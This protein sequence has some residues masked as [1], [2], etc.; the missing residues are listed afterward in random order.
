[1]SEWENVQ[2]V[3]L[4]I[5]LD[6]L[7]M[8]LADHGDASD[9]FLDLK[10]GEMVVLPRSVTAAAEEVLPE[11]LEQWELGLLDRARQV[12]LEGTRYIPIEPL[13][14]QQFKQVMEDFI[15]CVSDPA[16]ATSLAAVL[17]S[18]RAYTGFRAILAHW[19]QERTRWFDFEYAAYAELARAWLS[20][21]GVVP[22][23]IDSRQRP[24]NL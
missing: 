3:E 1:M 2:L 14:S 6:E 12:L 9:Y 24:L 4:P 23:F 11:G 15:H 22:R 10:T 20:T 8:A 5:N 18:P 21:C 16:L 19:P 13:S 17:D 7:Q